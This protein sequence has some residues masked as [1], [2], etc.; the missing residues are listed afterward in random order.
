[1]KRSADP[2]IKAFDDRARGELKRTLARLVDVF[3]YAAVKGELLRIKREPKR[4][5][6]AEAEYDRLL[7][8]WLTVERERQAASPPLTAKAACARL[9]KGTGISTIEGGKLNLGIGPRVR[10]RLRTAATIEREYKRALALMR[11]DDLLA[12]TWRSI[13][14]GGRGP[15]PFESDLKLL[16]RL[17]RPGANRAQK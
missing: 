4:E 3:G 9:A 16:T 6:S 8:V 11:A 5:R 17:V 15:E 7:N 13:L 1:M 14:D 2:I 12:A 10:S